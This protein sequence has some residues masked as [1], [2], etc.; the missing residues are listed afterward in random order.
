MANKNVQLKGMNGD[1]LFPKTKGAVVLNNDGDALGTVQAGA[2][3]NVIEKVQLNGVDLA[4]SNKTVNVTTDTDTYTIT[5]AA[6]P[7]SGMSATYQLY[8]GDTAVGAKINIPS[9]M[10]VSSGSVEVCATADVPVEGMVP[11]DKYIDLVLAN[12]SGSHVYIPVNDLVDVYTQGNGISISNNQISVDTTVIATKSDIS[13]LTTAVNGKADQATTLAGYGITNAYT[14]GEA[15][16]LFLTSH[17]DISGKLDVSK[18]KNT[19]STTSGDVY[20]AP[21]INSKLAEK[22]NVIDADHKLAAS[23]VS[24]LAN[25]AT[26]GSYSDLSGAPTAV[27]AFTNDA[28]YLVSTDIAGKADSATTL[29]GYGITDAIVYEELVSA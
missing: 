10:V 29:A 20:D 15:D 17:Q 8:K 7:D 2:Q 18:V 13:T 14:K 4:I 22:Q 3:V 26:S 11:G 24:G 21:Y 23:N 12:S 27:S 19:I 1:L 25:I 28:G 16:E 5:K 6:T 9:D